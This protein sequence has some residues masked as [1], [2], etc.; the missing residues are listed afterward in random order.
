MGA[1]INSTNAQNLNCLALAKHLNK[2][3]FEVFSLHVYS[4]NL[5]RDDSYPEGVTIFN[6]F[7]PFK[8]SK[9]LGYFWGIWRSDIVYLPK[10]EL[11]KFNRFWIKVLRKR[12]FSTVE[13]ILDKTI[14]PTEKRKRKAM[15]FYNSF[16]K[17]Y[18][19]T[20]FMK[21][22]NFRYHGLECEESILYL[23]TDI[24]TF[25]QAEQRVTENL[26]NIV[27]IGNDLIRKGIY[28]FFEIAKTLPEVNFHI[29]GTGIGKINV[30]REVES[31]KI[32]NITYHGGLNMH[33][34]SKLLRS[35]QIH[36]LPSRSEGFPKVTLET[37]AAGVPSIVYADYGANEWISHEKDGFV[38][39]RLEEMI[40]IIKDLKANPDKLNRISTNAI[41]L[42]EQ[43]D[44]KVLVKDWEEEILKLYKDKQ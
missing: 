15:E 39:D 40:A 5:S 43:F 21:E 16:E 19:I 18:S 25:R 36:I 33:Q 22:Y 1:Y 28:D 17:L 3:Q 2:N 34:L 30:N 8:L 9:Y 26:Q 11:V 41:A 20:S 31:A 14:I 27:L 13:G 4:G 6:C 10:G 24:E 12:A 35:M 29:V 44:W 32:E 7:R 38:V 23:G 37:A 42:A